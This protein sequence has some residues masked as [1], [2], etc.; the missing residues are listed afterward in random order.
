M[1]NKI[2]STLQILLARFNGQVLIPF[3]PASESVGI[4]E[5]TARNK[6]SNDTYPIR[7]VMYGSRRFIHISDLA[8]FVESLRAE[9]LKPTRG[10]PTKASKIQ[11]SQQSERR[12]Q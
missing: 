6:L 5:Q 12:G 11:A 7:T 3:A 9:S 1:Q 2:S 10:R 4:P 8:N